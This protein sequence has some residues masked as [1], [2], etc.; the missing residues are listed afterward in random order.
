MK[1]AILNIY[2]VNIDDIDTAM[3]RRVKFWVFKHFRFTFNF[4]KSIQLGTNSWYTYLLMVGKYVKCM[5]WTIICSRER[6]K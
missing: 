6:L 2:H 5:D 3:F 1:Y 4:I